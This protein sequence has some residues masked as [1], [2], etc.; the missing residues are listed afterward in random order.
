MRN[1]NAF[2]SQ[3]FFAFLII[4][5]LV[6]GG[7]FSSASENN[8]GTT[9]KLC[10]NKKTNVVTYVGNNSCPKDANTLLVGARG[11]KGEIG[12]DGTQGEPGKTGPQGPKGFSLLTGI[13]L[14]TAASGDNGDFFFDKSQGNLYGPKKEDS[15]GVPVSLIGPKGEMG[16]TGAQGLQ[17]VTGPQGASGVSRG[18][19]RSLTA[20][21]YLT[22]SN[23][24]VVGRISDLPAG[25]YLVFF[26]TDLMNWGQAQ[27]F[28]C[29]FEPQGGG[30]AYKIWIPEDSRRGGPLLESRWNYSKNGAITIPEGGGSI[31]VHCKVNEVPLDIFSL[32]NGSLSAIAVDNLNQS[33]RV[34]NR[35]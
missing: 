31:E 9:Y 13:G 32:S 6:A 15:W 11:P 5:I 25:K 35:P 2:K 24:T 12:A 28:G 30:G 17:G 16:L 27:Y 21:F 18:Y 3:F 22:T 29:G 34:F 26:S 10:V 4:S 8:E 33:A 7:T 14:P 20:D 19:F 1:L 23:S